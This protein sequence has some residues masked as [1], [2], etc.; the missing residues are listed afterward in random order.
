MAAPNQM[1]FR[2]SAKG[3]HLDIWTTYDDWNVIF[4]DCTHSDYCYLDYYEVWN[5][6]VWAILDYKDI[7]TIAPVLEISFGLPTADFGSV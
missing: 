1:N 5:I 6:T 4:F 7:R 2:K 3:G